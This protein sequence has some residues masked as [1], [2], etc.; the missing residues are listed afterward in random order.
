M[1]I[2]TELLEMIKR[3]EEDACE[4]IELCYA[5]NLGIAPYHARRAMCYSAFVLVRVLRTPQ[6][7]QREMLEDNIER[8]RQAMSHTAIS[9]DD[10]VHKMSYILEALPHLEDLKLSSSISSRISASI[11]YDTLRVYWENQ[12]ESEISQEVLTFDFD[13]IDWDTLAL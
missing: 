3:A 1:P 13:G 8:V 5:M 10:I 9:P 11:I 12:Q 7:L 2:S 4:L 6:N